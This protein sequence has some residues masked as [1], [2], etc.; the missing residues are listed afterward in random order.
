MI[1]LP[2]VLKNYINGFLRCRSRY[3]SCCDCACEGQTNKQKAVDSAG[4]AVGEAQGKS[5]LDSCESEHR[6]INLHL[7]GR[8]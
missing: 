7:L 4:S 2:L 5:R 1:V 8:V 3:C 6:D